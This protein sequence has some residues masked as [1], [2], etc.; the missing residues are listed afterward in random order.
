[1]IV[2]IGL[3]DRRIH[4]CRCLRFGRLNRRRL[5]F[6]FYEA[7]SSQ[8]V[9]CKIFVSDLLVFFE[10]CHLVLGE[11][12]LGFFNRELRFCQ[13]AAEF[14]QKVSCRNYLLAM[15]LLRRLLLLRHISQIEFLK[16]KFDALLEL[17]KPYQDQR[18]NLYGFQLELLTLHSMIFSLHQKLKY[19][20]LEFL[21]ALVYLLQLISIKPLPS[22]Q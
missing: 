12:L 2:P 3:G 14:L 10:A 18:E 22:L 11:L 7:L 1:M 19:L 16:V 13:N 6:S 17:I 21:K 5:C 20:K 4:P 9:L 15:I 8:L